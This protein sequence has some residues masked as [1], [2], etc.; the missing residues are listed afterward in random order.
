M[1]TITNLSLHFRMA[2]R[3]SS[4]SRIRIALIERSQRLQEALRAAGLG[5]AVYRSCAVPRYPF[6][7]LIVPPKVSRLTSA[8]PFPSVLVDAAAAPQ[9]EQYVLERV[10][11]RA[12][13]SR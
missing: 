4:S 7:S 13:P 9:L 11:D 8:L 12:T 1:V 6:R 10:E 5:A 3:K 2:G